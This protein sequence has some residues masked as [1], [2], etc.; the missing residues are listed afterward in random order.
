MAREIKLTSRS[1]NIIRERH[2]G[3]G[4]AVMSDGD[5]KSYTQCDFFFRKSDKSGNYVLGIGNKS[6][7][8][9][10]DQVKEIGYYAKQVKI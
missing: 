9:T 3:S 4:I 5:G 7:V 10:E 2:L 8:L 1:E 6:I